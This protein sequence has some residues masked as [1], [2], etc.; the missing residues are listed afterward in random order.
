MRRQRGMILHKRKGE[1]LKE[2]AQSSGETVISA[3][4]SPSL[5]AEQAKDEIQGWRIQRHGY[6]E[7][8]LLMVQQALL[9]L[10]QS[11]DSDAEMFTDFC[12][13]CVVP[14]EICHE[15]GK[16]ESQGIRGIRDQ[17]IRQKS[18]RCLT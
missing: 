6:A 9:P 14:L 1:S 18:V 8:E 5:A 4:P 12:D 17:D 10:V 16:L 2:T 13:S 3:N 7:Q 11:R 15:Q